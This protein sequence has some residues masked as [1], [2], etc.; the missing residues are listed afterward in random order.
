[1]TPLPGDETA[2]RDAQGVAA[3][4]LRFLAVGVLSYVVDVG[5]LWVTVTRLGWPLVVGATVA[6]SLAFVVNFG[7]GRRWVF[8]TSAQRGPQVAR[9]V[10]LV[11]LNY[12][13]TLV[14]LTSLTA[15]GHGLVVAKTISE[16]VNAV[17]NFWLGRVWVYR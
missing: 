3:Q 2:A 12:V 11:A 15:V 6:F 14:A 1:M 9:Y 16:I 13:L 10:V 8:R 17:I 4:A 5:T 7:L